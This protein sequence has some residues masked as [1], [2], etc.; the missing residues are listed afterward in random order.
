MAQGDRLR[1]S[2]VKNYEPAMSFG[3]DIADTYNDVA[4]GG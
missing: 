4:R 1:S 3:E 2:L